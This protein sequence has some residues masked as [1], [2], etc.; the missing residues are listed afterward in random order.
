M[1]KK[2]QGEKAPPLPARSSLSTVIEKLPVHIY[3]GRNVLE[4][5][6]LPWLM[7]LSGLS[8]SLQT[9]G[10]L[11]QFPIKTHAW[12][13]GQGPSRGHMRGN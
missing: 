2:M 13:A 12:V 1:T 8:A 6:N 10:L 4:I 3:L 11:V 9:K 7:W 5:L